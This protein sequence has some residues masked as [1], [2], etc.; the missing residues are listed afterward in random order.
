MK[1][2]NMKLKTKFVD[3]W[4]SPLPLQYDVIILK[5][6]IAILQLRVKKKKSQLTEHELPYKEM[7]Y[8]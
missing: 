8:A 3:I 7:K 4:K 6:K 5:D 1:N 2:V